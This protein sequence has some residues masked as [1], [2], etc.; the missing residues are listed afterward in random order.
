MVLKCS[1][2]FSLSSTD[3]IR[4]RLKSPTFRSIVM[5][6]QLFASKLAYVIFMTGHHL[7]MSILNYCAYDKVSHF[8]FFTKG[9]LYVDKNVHRGIVTRLR[10][11]VTITSKE[12]EGKQAR[13][14]S[15]V[16]SLSSLNSFDLRLSN[17]AENSI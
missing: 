10:Y 2:S 1:R 17:E 7:I 8:S 15:R 9:W 6:R 11:R 16:N 4:L 12:K 14:I 13:K 3:L 5:M